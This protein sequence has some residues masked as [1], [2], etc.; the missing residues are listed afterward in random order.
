MLK[1]LVLQ[2]RSYR[3]FYQEKNVD[4][5]SLVELVELAKNH[6]DPARPTVF[7]VLRILRVLSPTQLKD[8]KRQ[9]WAA[10]IELGE[11]ETQGPH[12]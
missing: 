4:R 3:R 6:L 12:S 8:Q 5:E 10:K 9:L 11:Q 7:G 2:N 1:D